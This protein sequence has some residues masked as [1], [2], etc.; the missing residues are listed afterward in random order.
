[1]NTEEELLIHM[2]EIKA[3]FPTEYLGKR[4]SDVKLLRMDNAQGTYGMG[5]FDDI[6]NILRP[7]DLLVYNDSKTIPSSF[8]GYSDSGKFVS[9]NI[10]YSEKYPLVEIR[11]HMGNHERGERI[12]FQNQSYLSLLA[13]TEMY[14]RYWYAEPSSNFNYD[15]LSRESGRFISYSRELPDFPGYIYESP[16]STKPGSVEYPSA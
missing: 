1:M 12:S 5:K 10:G 4:R 13:R 2:G 8:V 15:L 7:G 6:I 14:P 9:V 16:L 11:D 3:G